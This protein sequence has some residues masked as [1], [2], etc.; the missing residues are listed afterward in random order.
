LQ[1]FLARGGV[2][3][4][5]ASEKLVLEGRVQVNGKTVTTLG[6]KIAPGD[7]VCLDGVPVNA[8]KQRR[9]LLLNKPSEYLCSSS[10]PQGRPLALSLIPGEISERL[11][12]VGRLDYRSCGLVIF[13]ND[14]DFAARVSHPSSGIEKEYFIEAAGPVPDE[15]IR[16]IE[17]GVAVE[18]IRY[19]ARRIE[20][21]GRRALKV[22]L[23]EGKNREIR[24][25]FSCFHLHPNLLRRIRIGP[26]CL[27]D[28]P[29]GK[30]RPLTGAEI[31]ALETMRPRKAGDARPGGRAKGG[32]RGNRD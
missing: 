2:A 11:Y 5:R 17:E 28:L 29:E 9:Y 31:S 6:E 26:V 27:G 15:F 8:E 23:V 14:G 25:V 24:K 18:G 3:S 30:T 20:R 1:V 10:D 32:Y 19:Q 16:S 22:V 4:R 21:V 12:N 13:T 7:R